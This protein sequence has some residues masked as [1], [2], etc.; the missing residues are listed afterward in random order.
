MIKTDNITINTQS[1]V[2]IEGTQILYFDPYEIEN[3][4]YDADVIFITHDHYDHFDAESIAK[5]KKDE[6]V[7]VAPESMKNQ[8]IRES[9][10]EESKCRFFLP[11]TVHEVGKLVVETV[12]AYNRRKPFHPKAK[13]WMGYNVRMDEITYY[14]S[15]DTDITDEAR[16]VKC[17]VAIVPIGGHFTM[18][19]EQAAK[20]VVSIDPQAAIPSHYGSVVGKHEDGDKFREAVHSENR[21]ILIDLKL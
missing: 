14:V 18:D 20:L 1:S 21:D 11:G 10:I 6:T 4:C 7:L 13:H 16:R 12:P 5:V 3:D 2:R 19:A 17:D 15:G 8:V 9:G